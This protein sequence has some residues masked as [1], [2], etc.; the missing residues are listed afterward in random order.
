MAMDIASKMKAIRKA[1]EI[2]QESSSKNKMMD[3]NEMSYVID[4]LKDMEKQL[5]VEQDEPTG[6]A[7]WQNGLYR[8]NPIV[9]WTTFKT[10]L[11]TGGERSIEAAAISKRL[12]A[13]GTNVIAN[14][15]SNKESAE[16]VLPEIK[17]RKDT[18][19]HVGC[20]S[21]DGGA[22]KVLKKNLRVI[23]IFSKKL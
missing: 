17:A 10:A 20:D 2:L 22:E 4:T 18:A 12:A 14:Y 19:G 13:R 8:L 23:E 21:S 15:L 11:V 16:W 6:T 5:Q 3:T 9:H 1:I 7:W